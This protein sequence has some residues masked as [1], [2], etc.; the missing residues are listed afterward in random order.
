MKTISVIDCGSNSFRMLIVSIKD[1]HYDILKREYD[2]VML[3]KDLSTTNGIIDIDIINAGLE[4]FK[5]YKSI[6]DSFSCEKYFCIGT[7][8]LRTANNANEFVS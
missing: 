5:R 1:N 3:G 6:M 4:V 2:M 8:A 7:S